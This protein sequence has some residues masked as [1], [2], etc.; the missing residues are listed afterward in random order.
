[1]FRSWIQAGA[2]RVPGS[3]QVEGIVLDPPEIA[4]RKA[5]ESAQIRVMARFAGGSEEDITLFSDFRTNDDAVADVSN[6]GLIRA[7][8]PGNTAIVVSYRGNVLPVRV[9]VP[10]ELRAGFSYPKVPEVN[11]ID[12]EVFARLRQLN[13]VPSD[14]SS[15]EE[16]LRRIYVDTIGSLPSPEEVRDFLADIARLAFLCAGIPNVWRVTAHASSTNLIF[17]YGWRNNTSRS[18]RE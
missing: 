5:G 15:D 9:L 18:S 7:L 4:F 1:M 11:F 14:L 6:L 16:F 2:P 8:Q 13:M 3:G 12:R 17:E 10:M